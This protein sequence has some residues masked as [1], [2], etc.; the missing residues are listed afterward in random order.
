MPIFMTFADKI[1]AY[2]RQLDLNVPL[3][4]GIRVMN[5]YQDPSVLATTE[6]FYTRFYS[7][8]APRRLI[9]GINPGRHGAGVTGIPFTDTVRLWENC[10]IEPIGIPTT[11]ELSSVFVYQVVEA[12]G[13]AVAFY[14]DFY[15][16]SVCP[17]GFTKQTDKGKEVNYNYYDSRELTAAVQDFVVQ[18]LK[19]LLAMGFERD[20]CFCLG[21]GQNAA[22]LNKINA[23]Y[24][25][26]NQIIPL[27][28]PRFIMQYKSK[29]TPQYVAAFLEKLKMIRSI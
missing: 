6:V 22:F 18:N 21:T 3:P 13:G 17:L 8:N 7:D 4:D 27:E 10:H 24:G 11:K 16:N 29:Q 23:Q 15:I 26:F 2:N 9:M 25:F 5:P 1:N 19:T 12:Y 28:H 14:R 20:V